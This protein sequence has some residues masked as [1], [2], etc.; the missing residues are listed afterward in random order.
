MHLEI[1]QIGPGSCP[2]CGMALEPMVVSLEDDTPNPE[3]VDFR[4]RF[5]VGAIFAL[6]VL[7][8]SM[9]GDM[10]LVDLHRFIS[11]RLSAWLQFILATPVMLWSGWP[12]FERGVQS[13]ISRNLNM[14]TLIALGTGAAYGYSAT[15]TLLPNLFPDALRGDGGS[16]PVYFEAAAVIIVLVLLGQ[17]LELGA[18]ART[19][20]ALKALLG[21]APKTARRIGAEGRDEEVALDAVQVGHR[22]RVRPGE[23]VPVDGTVTDGH[24]SVDESMITGEPVPVEKSVGKT[25]IGGTVNGTGGFVMTATQVGAE[26]MLSRIVQMVAEAQRSQA[27]I[28][29]LADQV[30]GFFVPAVVAVA[31]AAFVIWF[32]VGPAP[33]MSYALIAAV[34]VLII[35]C[36]C[37]LGLATP[38]SVMVGTGRGASAGVLIKDAQALEL[39]EKVDTLVLDKT[40]TLTEGHPKVTAVE[41]TGEISQ[42]DL[43]CLV[44]SLERGSEHPLANAIL[45]AAEE[46]GLTLTDVEDLD[47]HTGMGI[48]GT[49]DGHHVSLGNAALMEQLNINASSWTAR[50]DEQRREGATV[51]LIGLDGA[52]AGLVA[53]E[54]PIKA[55]TNEALSE[56]REDGLSIVMLTGDNQTTAQAVARH[57]RI[58][59]VEADVLPED[60]GRIVQTLRDNGHIVAMAG[61]GINDAPAL[62]MADVGIAM[63]TGTDI[64]IESAGITLLQ[65]DLTALVRA[66]R[67]SRGVMRNIRQNL[68]FAFV[69]NALGVPIA[70]GVLYPVFGLLLSPMIA[71][72]AMSLSS[73]SVVGNALRLN[74]LSLDDHRPSA[75]R[76]KR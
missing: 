39:F 27:P 66:R 50:A 72:A 37:A 60:K 18:R 28:Q 65:G 54:D 5:L 23:K 38:I 33:S 35:A 61:D 73:V 21:L 8:L 30:A 15:A 49:V 62:A 10:G 24:S 57:L 64:A 36:P 16:V 59:H 46:K 56:L 52:P 14:F 6:P 4:H 51:V 58:G 25:V 67:L 68:F 45:S 9:V 17:I 11:P 1:V 74:A 19:G 53:V 13:L 71:A 70:A 2:I 34:S 29:R 7:F 12:F 42:D 63:G 47:V 43:L 41:T 44:A 48:S 22:L 40:G 20:K 76:T 31:V 26:T 55:T 75:V 69:Y 32:L 3:L